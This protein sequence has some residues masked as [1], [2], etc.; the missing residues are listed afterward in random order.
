MSEQ[1]TEI[2]RLKAEVNCATLL[3]HLPPIWR[4]DRAESTRR[5]LIT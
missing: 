3:E 2:E 1:D 4:L 5:S